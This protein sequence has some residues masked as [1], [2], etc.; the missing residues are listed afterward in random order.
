MVAPK[1]SPA[2]S[3]EQPAAEQKGILATPWKEW[4]RYLV[5]LIWFMVLFLLVQW[6]QA[7]IS[8]Y[9]FDCPCE[10]FFRRLQER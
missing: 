3:S 7:W 8:P 5:L 9:L 10:Q 6:I 4:L 2:Q 1:T